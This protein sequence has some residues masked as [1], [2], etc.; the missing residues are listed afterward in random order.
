M[1][2][3]SIENKFRKCPFSKQGKCEKLN[4]VGGIAPPNAE[5]YALTKLNL[6]YRCIDPWIL[7]KLDLCNPH[8]PKFRNK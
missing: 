3:K 7:E 5:L 4:L 1:A 2:G 6:I 8:H